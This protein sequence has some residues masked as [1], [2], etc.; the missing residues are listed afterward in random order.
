MPNGVVCLI[1]ALRQHELTTQ[2]PHTVWMMI[3]HKARTPKD[4]PVALKVVRA[5]GG[6]F[7]S[8]IETVAIEGVDVPIYGVAKTVADCFKY[9]HL[10]DEDVAIE[11]LRDALRY[12]K[13]TAS[14]I[15]RYAAIDRCM[16]RVEPLIR[17]LQE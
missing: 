11:A 15:M 4:P 2:L 17:A 5:S 8:G 9:R 13:A 12:R 7:T 14:E 1:S 6:A 16:T 3:S 10:V